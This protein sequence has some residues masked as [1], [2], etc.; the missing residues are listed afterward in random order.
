MAAENRDRITRATA[1][2]SAVVL[3][4][5][6]VMLLGDGVPKVTEALRAPFWHLWHP[7]S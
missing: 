5:V 6:V 3:A 1:K 2:T 7:V 4:A